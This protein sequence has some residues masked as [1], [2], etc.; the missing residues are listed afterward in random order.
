MS[1]D[2]KKVNESKEAYRKTLAGKPIAE[3][4]RLLDVMRENVFAIR[5]SKRTTKR[6]SL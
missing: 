4:L 1:F 5:K 2:W 3:K 6:S